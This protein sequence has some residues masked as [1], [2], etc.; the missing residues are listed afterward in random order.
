MT[1][2]PSGRCTLNISIQLPADGGTINP[3]TLNLQPD[4]SQGHFDN[5]VRS[6]Q[7][8]QIIHVVTSPEMI[9]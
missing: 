4:Y 8:A 1:I 2:R 9:V 5:I 6:S 3:T 7:A